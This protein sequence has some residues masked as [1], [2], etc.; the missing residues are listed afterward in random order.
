MRFLSFNILVFSFL[1]PMFL[2]IVGCG[3]QGES[4]GSKL[5]II[6]GSEVLSSESFVFKSTVA[7]THAYGGPSFCTG[8][9]IAD[10]IV[11]TAA[12]CLEDLDPRAKISV[13]FG[14]PA[15]LQDDAI[16][17][18]SVEKMIPHPNF[19]LNELEGKYVK[20]NGKVVPQYLVDAPNDIA[21]LKLKSSI[22]S[23]AMAMPVQDA[24]FVLKKDEEVVLA[25]FGA[26]EVTWSKVWTP[27]GKQNVPQGS[28]GNILR[29]V[30]SKIYL[31]NGISSE[32][33][34]ANKDKVS[35]WGDSGGP[36]FY[37]NINGAIE[38]IGATSRAL[39]HGEY[40]EE[41]V[42]YT[43]VR[44]FKSWIDAEVAKL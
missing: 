4:N 43:D 2:L 18:R 9:V 7:L 39:K 28:G 5:K 12:H 24:N 41:S 31:I 3:G 27:Y 10:K 44:K 42:I 23:W 32:L 40:C 16:V 22:P 13:R 1:T 36:A 15:V 33:Y 34:F 35:C 14:N 38:L 20:Y 11:V 30:E 8:T 25:G 29:E 19:K 17:M 26:D 21:I 37:K 6:G